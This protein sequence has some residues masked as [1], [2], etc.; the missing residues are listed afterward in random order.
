MVETRRDG[1]EAAMSDVVGR[2]PR[3]LSRRSLKV[4]RRTNFRAKTANCAQL[5][6]APHAL[7]H[8]PDQAREGG[9]ARQNGARKSFSQAT[10]TVK[11]L[12]CSIAPRSSTI[13]YHGACVQILCRARRKRARTI[14][15]LRS[16]NAQES[17]RF[18]HGALS[19]D[20]ISA[21]VSSIALRRRREG[22]YAS[23]GGAG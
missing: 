18:I 7:E 14:G 16:G 13:T 17:G 2:D 12:R 22:W 1:A 20:G 15:R 8:H 9:P 19:P 10:F 3:A 6:R 21:R 5:A 4:D 11:P 23:S